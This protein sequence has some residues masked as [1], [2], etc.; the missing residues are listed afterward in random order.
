M[1]L[2]RHSEYRASSE[3]C[4]TAPKAFV[5][6]RL[7]LEERRSYH[8]WRPATQRAERATARTVLNRHAC[9]RPV[10]RSRS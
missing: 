7:I 2:R 6:C 5:L 4:P 9:P 3:L 8:R 1:G 10:L